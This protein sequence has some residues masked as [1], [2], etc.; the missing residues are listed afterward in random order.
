MH[1]VIEQVI[2]DKTRYGETTQGS[3][4]EAQ[5]AAVRADVLARFGATLP[6]DYAAFL[7]RSNGINFN[8]A[9]LYGA[10]QTEVKPGPGGFWQGLVAAN[11][12]WRQGVGHEAY[13]VL[14]E[15]DMDLLTV[16]LD[17]TH[18]V[19]RDKVSSDVN[20]TFGS[21]AEAIETVLKQRL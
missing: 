11:A 6:D 12:R 7:L 10:T 19:L 4:T 1:V 13:L 14:G 15:T 16:D 17:G 20:D 3:A 8:G 5:V 18:P 21:V 9:Y 2:E